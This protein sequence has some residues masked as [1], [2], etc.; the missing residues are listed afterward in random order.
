V[1]RGEVLLVDVCGLDGGLADRGRDGQG[2]EGTRGPGEVAHSGQFVFLRET[3]AFC[4][5]LVHGV[6]DEGADGLEHADEDGR[7]VALVALADGL[8]HADEKHACGSARVYMRTRGRAASLCVGIYDGGVWS[9]SL[10]PAIAEA[11]E[12]AESID[13]CTSTSVDLQPQT[14]LAQMRAVLGRCGAGLRGLPAGGQPRPPAVAL[15]DQLQGDAAGELLQHVDRPL[16]LA[17]V[18]KGWRAAVLGARPHAPLHYVADL[19]KYR[20][21][22]ST[23]KNREMLADLAVKCGQYDVVSI[24]I[25]KNRNGRSTRCT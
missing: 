5:Y 18:S 15:I 12:D 21:S 4:D 10:M 9:M 23:D 24:K 22:T 14:T 13:T 11:D 3:C 17:Q 16:M 19:A 8:E 25:S 1:V 6:L 20:A 7:G 2:R